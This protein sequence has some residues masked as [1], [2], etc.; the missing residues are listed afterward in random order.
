MSALLLC[1]KELAA[2]DKLQACVS[3]NGAQWGIL[4]G[5]HCC[6][7]LNNASAQIIRCPR[8]HFAIAQRLIGITELMSVHEY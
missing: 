1:S 2:P 8:L 4:N 5:I 7:F 3:R 6:Y